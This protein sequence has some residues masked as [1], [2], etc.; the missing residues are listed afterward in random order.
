LVT[1]SVRNIKHEPIARATLFGYRATSGL[2]IFTGACSN[3]NMGAGLRYCSGGGK[4]NTAAR[5]CYERLFSVESKTWCGRRGQ[6]Q[7]GHFIHP[8]VPM[9][10]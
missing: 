4:P 6:W 7:V 5:S 9:C 10:T 2:Q 1:A 8:L 3:Y